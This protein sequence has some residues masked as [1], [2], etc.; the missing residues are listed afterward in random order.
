MPVLSR[1]AFLASA[2]ALA[3]SP[4]AFADDLP[5]R[6]RAARQGLAYGVC[7][8]TQHFSDTSFVQ[9]LSRETGI[10]VPEWEGKRG[11]IERL[12]GQYDFSAAD[13]LVGFAQNHGMESRGHAL[14]WHISNPAWLGEALDSPHPPETL[15]TDYIT[16]TAR[17]YRGKVQSWDV[18]NEAI[19]TE[20]DRPDGLRANQ[21]LKAF[22]PGYMDTA[23]HAAHAADSQAL[24]VY[25]DYG[26]ETAGAWQDK[27]RR[28]ALALLD[29]MRNRGVPCGALGIQAH[30][31]AYSQNFDER[32]FSDFL[33]QVAAMG[34]KILITE[35]DI[36]DEG[37]PSAP[38]QR[39]QKAAQL[40]KQFLDVALDQH[41]TTT[42]ITWG[43]SDRYTWLSGNQRPL[44]LDQNLH[45]K[46]MWHAIA[47]A[48]DAAPARVG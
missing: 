29:G 13:R 39:D 11:R 19:N 14:V 1:R 38:T 42:I 12:H 41:A 47:A 6:Q 15:L 46:P 20:D 44:P 17:H 8:A 16:A 30:L 4:P 43:L 48:L 36:S 26:L 2:A 37:G 9:A 27:R 22:G 31:K 45:R 28:T 10:L 40:T 21:W 33:S 32:I 3:V 18:V 24:L 35:L 5:L 7:A 34:Y 23:Y 25:N